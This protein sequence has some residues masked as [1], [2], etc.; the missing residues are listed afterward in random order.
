MSGLEIGYQMVS[1]TGATS[2]GKY[3]HFRENQNITFLYRQLLEQTFNSL[4][5]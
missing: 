4:E 1:C 3:R 2:Y 5:V